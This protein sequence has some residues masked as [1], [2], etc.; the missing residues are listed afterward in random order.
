MTEYELTIAFKEGWQAY[1]DRVLCFEN[2][3]EGV[4]DDL[5]Y[6]WDDGWWD[7]FEDNE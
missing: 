7:A 1:F 5:Y 4:S 6:R 2:P 3:Y